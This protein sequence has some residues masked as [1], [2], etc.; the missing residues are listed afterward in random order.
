MEQSPSWEAKR[1]SA[2]QKIPLMLWNPKVHYRFH[3]YPP[4]VLIPSQLDPVHTPH[5]TSWRSILIL[6]FHLRLVVPS[7][8]F[9]S[10]FSIKILYRPHPSILHSIPY[11][12]SQLYKVHDTL[13]RANV[14]CFSFIL[15]RFRNCRGYV[16]SHVMTANDKWGRV[17][18]EL[19]VT[20]F[21]VICQDKHWNKQQKPHLWAHNR[22][23]SSSLGAGVVPPH[24]FPWPPCWYC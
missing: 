12:N 17:C 23:K 6:S 9:P 14:V 19:I 8:F 1:F 2:S 7:G 13:N 15:L 3:K 22:I 10:S 4:P 24:K 18:K 20:C 11:K 16:L 5:T 21:N